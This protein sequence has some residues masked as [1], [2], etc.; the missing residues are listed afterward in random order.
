M[1]RFYLVAVFAAIAPRG[2]SAGP[3]N[4]IGPPKDEENP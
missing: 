2:G 3:G 4:G 1:L